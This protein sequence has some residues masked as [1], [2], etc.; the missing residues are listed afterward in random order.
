VT[1]PLRQTRNRERAEKLAHVVELVSSKGSQ[2]EI[3][4]FSRRLGFRL[5]TPINS[6]QVDR[7]GDEMFHHAHLLVYKSLPALRAA[8]NAGSP[9]VPRVDQYDPEPLAVGLALAGHT[10]ANL[11][12]VATVMAWIQDGKR[13]RSGLDTDRPRLYK[14]L[15]KYIELEHELWLIAHRYGGPSAQIPYLLRIWLLEN[16]WN[17]DAHANPGSTTICIRCGTRLWR[18]RRRFAGAPRCT[19]CMKETQ[20]QRAWPEHAVAPAG[21]GTW[22]LKC[23][24]PGCTLTYQAR[25]HSHYCP[26]HTLAQLTPSRRPVTPSA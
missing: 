20:Q 25:R 14:R 19:A 26:R 15:A 23:E 6:L 16:L 9:S 11:L 24:H 21:P 2:L 4:A 10:G 1:D 17:A 13:L 3:E 22:W 18:A 7:P 5:G 8:H 12:E